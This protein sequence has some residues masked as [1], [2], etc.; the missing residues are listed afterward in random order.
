MISVLRSSARFRS[1]HAGVT[2]WHCFSAGAHYDPDNVA[3]GRLIVCDEHL[4]EPGAG[5][6]WHAHRGVDI[7][8]WVLEGTLRHE[9][10]TGVE[11]VVAPGTA[12]VQ[13]TGSGIRHRET[14]ASSA[15]PL[16]VV[17]TTL[18]SDSAPSVAL[19]HGR[20]TLRGASFDVVSS[21][22]V[23]GG[24]RLG[25]AFVGR[26]AFEGGGYELLTG[27]SLRAGDGEEIR[28]TGAGQLLV[29]SVEV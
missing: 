27:D 19:A 1:E 2:S 22:C 20:L 15:L 12:L 21:S 17:H 23:L 25:H 13:S 5:F 11:H 4:L 7:V 18:L 8:S 10:T 28:L 24:G 16:R 3:F 14:N 9:D 29:V 6:D 26:G